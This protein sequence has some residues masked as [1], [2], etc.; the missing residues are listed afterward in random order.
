MYVPTMT[1]FS[2][3]FKK[4]FTEIIFKY[5]YIA[6]AAVISSSLAFTSTYY[7]TKIAEASSVLLDK[8]STIPFQTR[9]HSL[10]KFTFIAISMRYIPMFFFTFLI[11]LISREKFVE[12]LEQY[13]NLRYTNF[14]KK[15]PGEI[16]FT[17]FLKSFSY[18]ICAQ[19]VVFDVVSIIGSTLFTFLK[20]YREI[21]IYAAMIFPLFP[22]VYGIATLYF[23]KYRIVYSTVNLEEQ[24]KTSARIYDKLSNYDV[25]KTYNLEEQEIESFRE[26]VKDQAKS[27]LKSDIFFAKG[28]YIIKYITMAPYVILGLLSLA[29]PNT[30]NGKAL[31]QAILLFSSLSVQ[32]KKIGI[33]MARLAN[34]LNQIRFDAIEEEEQPIPSNTKRTFDNNIQFENVSIYHGE[35]CIISNINLDIKKG[36]KIAVVGSNGTGKSSF[37]KTIFG[38][39]DYTGSILIDGANLRDLSNKAVFNLISYIPQ[40][41]FTSDDTILNN[42][43]LGRRN[44]TREYI[45]SKAKQFKAHDTFMALEDGYETEAGIKGNKLSGG[46]KQ[47]LS[48]VRAAVKDSPIFILD[49]ATAAIDKSYEKVAMDI[50]LDEMNEKTV[51]MIIHEKDYLKRFD[52]IVF[53]RAG[54]LEAAGKYEDLLNENEHFREFI[55]K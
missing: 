34:L 39:V 25:I 46:Q 9:L 24:E 48:I 52:K 22:I 47:K 19:I 18:P 31:F 42:L 50:F 33:Q 54:K 26:S 28:K 20:A 21:N 2:G 23:L 16:R 7:F 41:D 37:I 5:K 3:L 27:Q 53:L 45:E 55:S 38:F 44:A 10:V 36:Q 49:E 30:M 40:D 4:I 6:G 12:N 11:Q 1:E 43:R 13:M 29:S 51:I 8:T 14:H 15:T 17:I 35:T 32:I